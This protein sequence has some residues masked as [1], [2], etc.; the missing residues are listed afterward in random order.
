[1]KKFFVAGLICLWMSNAFSQPDNKLLGRWQ[2]AHGSGQI[3][4]FKNPDNT[5]YGKLVW[6]KKPTDEKGQQLKDIHNP[7]EALRSRP[8]LGINIFKDLEYKGNL[9]WGG[10]T[11]YD[12]KSGKTYNCQ[13]SL[14]DPDKLYIRAFFGIALLGKTEIWTRVN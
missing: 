4:F 9:A 11:V 13:L 2:S 8:I 12:P 1:M 14:E 5:F 3:Q 10:G 7:N 6:L